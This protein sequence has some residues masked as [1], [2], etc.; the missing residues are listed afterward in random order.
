MKKI[1]IFI[2]TVLHCCSIPNSL[3]AASQKTDS[4][5]LFEMPLAD[6]MSVR[7]NT[8]TLTGT[9]VITAPVSRTVITAENIAVT[10]ARTIVDLIE[11]YVPGAT[12]V[13][14]WGLLHNLE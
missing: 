3:S 2:L 6:L 11:V 13:E 4:E 14:H 9:S 1:W 5:A 7:I 8:G 12:F 10:P